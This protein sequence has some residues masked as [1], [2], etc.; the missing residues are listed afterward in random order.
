MVFGFSENW[1]V[2]RMDIRSEPILVAVL[3]YKTTF[4]HFSSLPVEPMRSRALSTGHEPR[5][6]V[7]EAPVSSVSFSVILAVSPFYER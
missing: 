3:Q 7:L 6:Q 1:V 5:A 2:V 4:F